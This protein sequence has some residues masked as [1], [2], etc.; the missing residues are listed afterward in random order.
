MR[1]QGFDHGGADAIHLQKILLAREG[2][3]GWI[4]AEATGAEVDDGSGA[5]LAQLWKDDKLGAR[6]GIRVELVEKLCGSIALRR[7]GV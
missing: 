3:G 4:A 1:P 6:C 5:L 7:L 2:N